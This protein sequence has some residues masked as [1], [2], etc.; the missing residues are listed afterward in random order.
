MENPHFRKRNISSALPKHHQLNKNMMSTISG[1]DCLL[2]IKVGIKAFK[3][4]SVFPLEAI[5]QNFCKKLFI[6]LAKESLSAF[7]SNVCCFRSCSFFEKVLNDEK[8]SPPSSICPLDHRQN[9]S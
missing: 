3:N 6:A 1:V 5:T 9:K 7:S 2:V 8:S 4:A